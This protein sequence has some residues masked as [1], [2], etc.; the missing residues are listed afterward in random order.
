MRTAWLVAILAACGPPAT[1][2][3]SNVAPKVPASTGRPGIA[4]TI[5]DAETRE[6]LAGVTAIVN[7]HKDAVAITDEHGKYQIQLPGAG[8]Y[9][10][11]FYYL[12]LTV[13]RPIEVRGAA[14]IDQEI[15]QRW[16]RNGAPVMRC[17]GSRI[18]DCRMKK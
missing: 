6:A 7:D 15:D 13:E 9:T 8:Q 2:T 17:I 10:V 5:V 1:T 14:Q 16:S 11:T 3:V 4:G 18:V 12:D